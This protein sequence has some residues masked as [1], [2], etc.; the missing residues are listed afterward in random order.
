MSSRE[1]I[2]SWNRHSNHNF[3]VMHNR[4]NFIAH[5]CLERLPNTHTR[6]HTCAHAHTANKHR[7]M[8]QRPKQTNKQNKTGKAC[9]HTALIF[10]NAD[11]D[12]D[13]DPDPLTLTLTLILTLTRTLTLTD[14]HTHTQTRTRTAKTPAPDP[15]PYTHTRTH[16]H[17]THTDQTHIHHAHIHTYAPTHLTHLHTHT[18]LHTYTPTHICTRAIFPT[19]HRHV[20][21]DTRNYEFTTTKRRTSSTPSWQK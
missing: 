11:P 17:T 19:S 8:M 1:H 16:I 5:P 18:H 7:R 3:A 6:V 21:A 2:C 15:V 9:I 14:T 12:P 10:P 13:P 20:T 4:S